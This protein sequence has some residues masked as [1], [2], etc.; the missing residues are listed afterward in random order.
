MIASLEHAVDRTVTAFDQLGAMWGPG[1][2]P[3]LTVHGLT[4]DQ[5]HELG[6]APLT[7]RDGFSDDPSYVA[8][9]RVR[10]PLGWSVGFFGD[11]DLAC[12]RCRRL[13]LPDDTLGE[14]LQLAGLDGE[15]M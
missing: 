13:L 14:V 11:A 2:A 4:H 10:T 6:G 12:E 3:N 5:V 9:T 8:M 7:F 1:V 15:G